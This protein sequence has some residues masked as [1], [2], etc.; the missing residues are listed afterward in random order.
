[1]KI[2]HTF[3]RNLIFWLAVTVPHLN[4]YRR[5]KPA[6]ILVCQEVELPN[7]PIFQ[8]SSDDNSAPLKRLPESEDV[9][10]VPLCRDPLPDVRI[11]FTIPA[12]N[13]STILTLPPRRSTTPNYGPF[14]DG[15]SGDL[16]HVPNP[17]VGESHNGLQELNSLL[18]FE[19]NAGDYALPHARPGAYGAIGSVSGNVQISLVKTDAFHV[20]ANHSTDFG[21]F[22]IP[23]D[24]N[25]VP[26]FTPIISSDQ[27]TS[28]SVPD[29]STKVTSSPGYSSTGISAWTES[30]E[31]QHTESS[32]KNGFTDTKPY[33][34]IGERAHVAASDLLKEAAPR[35]GNCFPNKNW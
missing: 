6:K 4:A 1:M 9:P 5:Q 16:I 11:L 18:H 21:G 20:G 30:S 3:P 35:F 28:R 8:P 29:G 17:F 10:N 12:I 24:V 26:I 2:Q 14:S 22:T 15:G 7:L 23:G 33:G 32:T 27:S 13:Y 25:V 34:F 31:S 19:N